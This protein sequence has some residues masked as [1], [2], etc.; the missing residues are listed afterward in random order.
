MVALTLHA[1]GPEYVLPTD[2][3]NPNTSVIDIAGQLGTLPNPGDLL[4]LWTLVA[5]TNVRQITVPGWTTLR[6]H[7]NMKSGTT[8]ATGGFGVYGLIYSNE[9]SIT[10]NYTAGLDVLTRLL[11]ITHDIPAPEL[12]PGP[13]IGRADPGSGATNL[14][15]VAPS[16]D[17]P[18]PGY[19]VSVG[20]ER[21][22]A[23]ETREQISVNNGMTIWG[24]YGHGGT[25]PLV[26]AGK[27]VTAGPSGPTTTTYP[28][29]HANNGVGGHFLLA[30]GSTPPQP[31][32]T[33]RY[34]AQPAQ[35]KIGDG[36]ALRV[37]VGVRQMRPA[38]NV[39]EAIANFWSAHRGGSADYPEMSTY[40][41]GQA[42]LL[43]WPVL[44]IS[45]ARTS[46]G[47][48]FGAHDAYLDRVVTGTAGT[49]Y[50]PK[51]MTWAQVNALAIRS[52]VGG[53]SKPFQRLDDLLAK[54]GQHVLLVDPK[55]YLTAPDLDSLFAL[56][57]ANGGGDRHIL[58]W[59]GVGSGQ[60]GFAQRCA[61]EGYQSW[62]YF[63]GND[64]LTAIDVQRWSLL[65]MDYTAPQ[66]AWDNLRALGGNRPIFAHIC[67]TPN[68]VETARAKGADGYQ[69]SGVRAIRP[70]L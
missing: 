37:P 39:D 27:D 56:L 6:A 48:W 4:L 38:R 10:V 54:F 68:A 46:D 7:D 58:K 65:G 5:E 25:I 17:V 31:G 33:V 62:G 42:A 15:T 36:A 16:M 53:A 45:L 13:F 29:P 35:L 41:Y 14:T 60:H 44:E 66:Q 64:T 28:N 70:A 67:P 30:P 3:V 47:V 32:L 69:C 23:A 22:A 63:Y 49:T 50:D 24:Y 59:Y 40:A 19:L 57:N 20:T 21:T 2:S 52:P 34:G 1:V 8:T 61:A 26:L 11:R 9:T 55:G 12:I 51:A 18:K 43:G